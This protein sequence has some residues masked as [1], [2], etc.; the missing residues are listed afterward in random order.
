MAPVIALLKKGRKWNWS[1]EQQR[2]FEDIK[3]KLISAPVLIQPDFE[4]PFE[5]YCDASRVGLGAILTQNSKSI[6]F[7]VLNL[8]E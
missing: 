3:E 1:P 4:K 8:H 5:I 7:A 2:S 6:K